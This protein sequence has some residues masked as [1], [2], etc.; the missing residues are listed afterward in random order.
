MK[1][2]NILKVWNEELLFLS[3][4]NIKPLVLDLD[5]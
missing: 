2:S 4:E 1:L 3:R 5:I